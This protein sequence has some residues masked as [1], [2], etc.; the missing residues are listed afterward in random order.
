MRRFWGLGALV[1]LVTILVAVCGVTERSAAFSSFYESRCRSCHADDSQ[2]CN[3]CHYHRGYVWA[4]ADKESYL[5]GHPVTVTLNGGNQSGWI[6]AILYDHNEVEV[7]R[8]QGPD[9][10][11]DN[12]LGDPVVFPAAL[13]ATA[14]LEEGDYIWTAAWY[15]SNNFGTDHIEQGV[16]VTIT[17]LI[18]TAVDDEQPPQLADRQLRLSISP[19]PLTV[20]SMIRCAVGPRAGRAMLSILD[21]TGR[22]IRSLTGRSIAPGECEII[23][24][25]KDDRGL[26]VSAGVYL[27]VL[28][29]TVGSV[30]HPILV[31][32]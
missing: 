28:S 18:D 20:R 26:P 13:Q 11:G 32:R 10:T 29:G 30:A 6:R 23:W 5:P 22:R 19:N 27:A 25:G 1:V 12:G 7:A 21:A 4:Q 8:S 17:V 15:G 9:G 2:T 14:P 31:L 24:D 3:G 16:P